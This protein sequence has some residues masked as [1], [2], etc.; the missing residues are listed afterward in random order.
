M[1]EPSKPNPS[2][3]LSTS[4]SPSGR[5]KCCHVPGRSTKRTSTTSTPSALARSSTSRGLV[6][7]TDLVSTA[8]NTLHEFQR[9]ERAGP[10][11]QRRNARGRESGVLVTNPDADFPCDWYKNARPGGRPLWYGTA[12]SD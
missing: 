5:L 10:R 6:L 4:S 9:F 2:L 3:K 7:L 8:M 11:V 1:L 12:N